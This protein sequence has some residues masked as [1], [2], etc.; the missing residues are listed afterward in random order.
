LLNL[1]AAQPGVVSLDWEALSDPASA[2][3]VWEHCLELPFD[4][5]WHAALCE[6]NIQVDM[7]ERVELLRA[8][9][10]GIAA[11]KAEIV[12]RQS[13]KGHQWLN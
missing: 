11:M 6:V 5:V 8:N 4:W 13:S 12:R 9:Q 1:V 7:Y 10:A 2:K 3:V